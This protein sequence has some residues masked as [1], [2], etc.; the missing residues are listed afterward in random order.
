MA[1]AGRI[2]SASQRV[3]WR[4]L[5]VTIGLQSFAAAA[6]WHGKLD[7]ETWAW[8]SGGLASMYIGGDTLEKVSALIAAV[9]GGKKE[10]S[11]G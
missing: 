11:D 1:P 3:S 10:G 6:L 4:R 7:S 2:E 5:T 8:F 9:R